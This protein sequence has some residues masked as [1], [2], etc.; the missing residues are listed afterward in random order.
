MTS[1]VTDL[2]DAERLPSL[3]DALV[4]SAPFDVVIHNAGINR[5]GR[6]RQAD[7]D[8]QR[9]VFEINLLAPIL[10]TRE[11]F[12][13]G[14]LA[15]DCKLGFVS[16]LSH[17]VGYPRSAVYAATKTGLASFAASLLAAGRTAGFS[18][19]TIFP[20]PTRTRQAR[21]NSP[22]NSRESR[23]MDP[24]VLAAMIQPAIMSRKSILI[25]GAANRLAAFLGKQFPSFADALMRKALLR[26]TPKSHAGE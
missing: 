12:A 6:F 19:T 22:D 8:A 17:F 2:S 5:F 7:P 9:R 11:L 10:L 21:E 15:R 3:V 14:L 20:G 1:I 16:S 24:Q 13:R 26:P 23:R 18:V 25:P 4:A